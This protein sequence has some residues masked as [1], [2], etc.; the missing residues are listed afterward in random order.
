MTV[1]VSASGLFQETY[2]T[3]VANHTTIMG[4]KYDTDN[5]ATYPLRIIP[6]FVD[7]EHLSSGMSHIRVI[8]FR[9]RKAGDLPALSI[10]LQYHGEALEPVDSHL[11]D[12]RGHTGTDALET[13]YDIM[14]KRIDSRVRAVGD[15]LIQPVFDE[16]GGD[17]IFTGEFTIELL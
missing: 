15:L 11:D 6:N 13:C 14:R 3:L 4:A 16:E 5:I 10:Q 12:Q 7:T 1:T 17:W 8:L 2:D 9:Y